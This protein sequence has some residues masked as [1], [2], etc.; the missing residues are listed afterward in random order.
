[1]SFTPA[2][3]DNLSGIFRDLVPDELE[4]D[5]RFVDIVSWNIKFFN[6]RDNRRVEQIT[7][8]MKE[9]NADIF[10]LQEIEEGSLDPVAEALTQSGAGFYKTVYGSNG[11]D[12]RVAFMYDTEW[13]RASRLE[14]LFTHKPKLA[15]GKEIFPRLPLY[16]SFV[17]RADESPFD[18]ELVGVHLKSQRGQNRSKDQREAAAEF[19]IKWLHTEAEDEDVLIIGDWNAKSSAEEWAR[20]R[21]L[22]V[23]GKIRFS[24]WNP[25]SEVSH[26]SSNGRG[27]RLDMVVVTPA[28]DEVAV[29]EGTTIIRWKDL[30]ERR[31]FLRFVIDN[32]SDHLPVISRFRFKDVDA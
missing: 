12:Q 30:L 31:D 10:V 6:R 28:V 25:E 7:S 24:S 29:I 4:G 8:I 9:L 1:M 32:I 11:M 18:F 19:L 22:E 15:S 13:V 17:V 5:D 26:L 16:G 14:E 21:D 20:I 23:T 27:T 2:S 3:N